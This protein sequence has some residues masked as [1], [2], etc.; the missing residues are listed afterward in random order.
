MLNGKIADPAVRL[1]AHAAFAVHAQDM[2][3][4][5]A[6]LAMRSRYEAEGNN[7]Q[8]PSLGALAARQRVGGFASARF[9]E[10]D[11]S[12]L[13]N[14][15]DELFR[16]GCAVESNKELRAALTDR[17][18]PVTQRQG[19]IESILGGKVSTPRHGIIAYVVSLFSNRSPEAPTIA[20]LKYV[21]E[22]GRSR[23]AERK[24]R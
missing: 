1:A 3:A 22:G 21:V 13:A 4:S 8:E 16:F 17:E 14:I 23:F 24:D 5:L 19:I 20:L 10:L 2:P 18:L 15:E 6:Y 9:E 7:Y 11:V 12:D